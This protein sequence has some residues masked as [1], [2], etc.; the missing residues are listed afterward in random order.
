MHLLAGDGAPG[1]LH[2]LTHL[3]F[4][5]M[6]VAAFAVANRLS[7][8]VAGAVA[9][10][11]LALSSPIQENTVTAFQDVTTGA[12]VLLAMLFE[13]R[14]PRHG[15]A[16][17]TTLA[18][19]GLL[20]PEAWGL[21]AAYWLYLAVFSESWARRA[22]L[23]ALAAAGPLLWMLTD[24]VLTGEPFLSFTRTR[25]GAEAAQ[26]TTGLAEG[27]RQLWTNLRATLGGLVLLAAALAGLAA[28]ATLRRAHPL[29]DRRLLLPTAAAILL[30]FA[31]LALAGGELSL[32]ERYVIPLAG[33][34]AVL[35]GHGA[36]GWLRFASAPRLPWAVFGAVVVVA[37]LATAP[38]EI[39]QTQRSLSFSRERQDLVEA[40]D[41]V[42]VPEACR[43]VSVSGYRYRPMLAHQI[44]RLAGD[45]PLVDEPRADRVPGAWVLPVSQA[46]LTNFG[47]HVSAEVPAGFRE[48]QRTRDWLLLTSRC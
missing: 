35:A 29:A 14:R 32:L 15:V 36:G 46:A 34:L 48:A 20:R 37:L 19:A 47:P 44:D 22:A 24:L 42:R 27:P 39:D 11:V 26:R 6:V 21:A 25:E 7:G 38:R 31:F 41:E 5:G 1:V 23:A 28:A 3:S 33:V 43:T 4:A 10:L 13:L 2:G 45:L 40:L 9:G 16:A 18:F 12:L 17:L 30:G 8:P